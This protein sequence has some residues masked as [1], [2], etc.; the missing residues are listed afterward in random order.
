MDI[1]YAFLFVPNMSNRGGSICVTAM[2]F[3]V[4]DKE[5][6]KSVQNCLRLH[7]A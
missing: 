5:E 6:R 7:M 2:E 3:E 1:T 4:K